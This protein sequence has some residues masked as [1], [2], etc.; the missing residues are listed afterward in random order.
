MWI[1]TPGQKA[2]VFEY[3]GYMYLLTLCHGELN[4]QN[5]CYLYSDSEGK[6]TA[7]TFLALVH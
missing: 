3:S 5:P 1:G 2:E 4:I 6:E 7:A